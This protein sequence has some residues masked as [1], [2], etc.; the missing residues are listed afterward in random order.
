MKSLPILFSTPMVQAIADNR[1]HMTRRTQGLE[2]VNKI[3]NDYYFQSLVLHATGQYTFA[4]IQPNDQPLHTRIIECKPRYNVGDILWVK[5]TWSDYA[6]AIRHTLKNGVVIEKK[7]ADIII[8]KSDTAF[9][10]NYKWKS[11]LFMKKTHARLWLE[12]TNVRCERLQSIS[13]DDA[14]AEGIKF[15]HGT[16]FTRYFDYVEKEYTLR[17]PTHSFFSLWRSI[18]GKDSVAANPWVFVYEFKLINKT[19]I[20]P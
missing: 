15:V 12:V 14:I 20:K 18:N 9:P 16:D 11:S 3:P 1:K 6:N 4:P 13:H 19:N 5:E 17:Y 2:K 8:Y 10:Q 7:L